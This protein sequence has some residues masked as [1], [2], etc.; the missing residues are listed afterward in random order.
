[1][2]V[3]S[4]LFQKEEV[5]PEC[6]LYNEKLV[7]YLKTLCRYHYDDF[8]NVFLLKNTIVTQNE[9]VLKIVL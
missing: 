5:T 4:Y 2:R 1:M 9:H 8:P 6:Y 3:A 7:L